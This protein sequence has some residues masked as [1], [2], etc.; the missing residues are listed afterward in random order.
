[1]QKMTADVVVQPLNGASRFMGT[2]PVLV[3]ISSSNF[4]YR[5]VWIRQDEKRMSGVEGPQQFVRMNGRCKIV[6]Q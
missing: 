2:R 4:T 3:G 5:P 1:M 6:L